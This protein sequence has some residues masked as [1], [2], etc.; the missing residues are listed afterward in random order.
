M[1]KL[2]GGGRYACASYVCVE[3]PEGCVKGCSHPRGEKE[4]KIYAPTKTCMKGEVI[5][6]SLAHRETSFV[7]LRIRV[8]F[9]YSLYIFLI[10]YKKVFL[11]I[12][13]EARAICVQQQ[14]AVVSKSQ[15]TI[16]TQQYRGRLKLNG[17]AESE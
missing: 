11:N 12:I 5:N 15:F 8:T 13:K 9:N 4:T 2:D 17:D 3:L 10:L 6:Y 16:Y 1:C 14:P 7:Y